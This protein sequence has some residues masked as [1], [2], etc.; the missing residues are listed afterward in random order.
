MFISLFS[1]RPME[2]ET[3]QNEAQLA[4]DLHKK[5]MLSP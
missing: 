2:L 3:K 1:F 5:R 4:I